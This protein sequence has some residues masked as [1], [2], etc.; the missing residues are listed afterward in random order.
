MPLL[1]GGGSLVAPIERD[2]RLSSGNSLGLYD[3]Q[4]ETIEEICLKRD[5]KL[6]LS[7]LNNPTHAIHP[8]LPPIK[9]TG[10]DM[11]K[12]AHNRV[13]PFKEN[14]YTEKSF[15]CRMLYDLYH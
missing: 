1:R 3:P 7:V 2:C 5:R 12:R 9:T 6:I 13:L 4:G 8:L 15:I 14:S 10:Y 11:C